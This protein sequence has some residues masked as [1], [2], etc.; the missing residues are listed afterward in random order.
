MPT[1]TSQ[2]A[3]ALADLFA[4][5]TT[6]FAEPAYL[7]GLLAELGYQVPDLTGQLPLFTEVMAIAEPLAELSSSAAQLEDDPDLG[8]VATTMV[9]TA[10]ALFDAIHALRELR[11][12]DLNGLVAPFD[13]PATWVELAG[14]LPSY[15]V[16]AWLEGAHPMVAGALRL[17]GVLG[18]KPAPGA[19]PATIDW[20][21]LGALVS[22]PVARI[23]STSG[24]GGAFDHAAL[25]E[26]VAEVARGAGYTP[27]LSPLR[28]DLI[29]QFWNGY[30]GWDP[31][32]LGVRLWSGFSLGGSTYTRLGLVLAAVPSTPT[33]TTPDALLLTAAAD[34]DLA[35]SIAV[36]ATWTA[37]LAGTVAA[38]GSLGAMLTP[39]GLLAVTDEATLD[40]GLELEAAPA[41]PWIV[42]GGAGTTRFEVRG[43]LLGLSL[44]GTTA[45]PELIGEVRPSAGTQLVLALGD[46]DG[47]LGSLLGT[48]EIAIA[49]AP[50]LRW[51]SRDGFSFGGT[52]GFEL[53]VPIGLAL[54]PLFIDR[55]H[56]ALT[57]GDAGLEL[58]ATT[59]LGAAL[60]PFA[61][62]VEDIGLRFGV[63]SRAADDARG[64]FGAVGVA[65]GFLPP[66]GLGLAV[67]LGALG[68]GG[69]YLEC[70]PDEGKYDGV[71]DLDLLG[72]GVTAIG[73][74]T[75][76]AA[77]GWSLFLS[78]SATFTGVQL[79]FGFTLNG[80]GGL[81]GVN[82]A[83]DL[84]AL[85]D[86]VRSGALE[87]LLFPDDPVADAPRILADLDAI[88]PPA[89]GQYVFGPMAKIGWGTP[90]LATVDLG[91]VMQLPDPIT[92]SLLGSFEA[93]LPAPEA[94]ILELRVDVAGT[95]DVTNGTL[96]VDASLRDSRVAGLALSGDMSMRAVFV[97]Q[98]SFLMSF[99]GFNPRFVPPAGF[100]QLKRLSVALDGGDALRLE[101]AGYFA[102]TSNTVQFGSSCEV[103][104]HAVGLTVEGDFHFDALL[105]FDPFWFVIDLGFGV[106]VRAGSFELFAVHLDFMLEG[107]KP[108]HALGTATVKILGV[109]KDF[110][111]EVTLGGGPTTV[112]RD[113]IDVRALVVD[114]L[115]A[116]DAWREL[117]PAADGQA[118]TLGDVPAGAE[119]RVHPASVLEVRQRVAPLDVTLEQY[120]NATV[121]G[122]DR[123]ELS[124]P[125]LGGIAAAG[126]PLTDWFA[127]AQYFV[128]GDAEKLSSPSFELMTCGMQLGEVGAA[129]GPASDLELGYEQVVRDPDVTEQ[130]V[131]LAA[132]HA[133]TSAALAAAVTRSAVATLRRSKGLP[134]AASAATPA[135][136]ALGEVRYV[137][138]DADTG[139]VDGTVTPATGVSWSQARAARATRASVQLVPS[140]EVEAA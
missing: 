56:V 136:F 47:F 132:V 82:R 99:G 23:R 87:G 128:L 60:G 2:L 57:G 115:S 92:V 18:R 90:T 29:D 27:A 116:A 83:V 71:A 94:P 51:S 30:A 105:Q 117:A 104:A 45:A 97:G 135:A 91:I 75:T 107:P 48:G 110:H 76:E 28:R 8:A 4:P 81:V 39:S 77:G 108:W 122:L 139:A 22:D 109:K 55:V 68:G 53:D 93:I 13:E 1:F 59:S 103:Y 24:F 85:S 119:L 106:T 133:P 16:V 65:L 32:E 72:I 80:V 46:A 74:L 114:A 69:G 21:G 15:L 120:G 9:E 111:V 123:F 64:N 124:A 37:R 95:L 38:T 35:A 63:E 31:R 79:G 131:P 138:T 12:N 50:A 98:P 112:T 33:S 127:P 11:A 102:I 140:Y 84:D 44:Q 70:R 34:G 88:F 118:V 26:A 54:G 61:F 100:P 25:L 89:E 130:D 42:L 113:A 19:P 10:T 58:R 129:A 41:A 5:L 134:T 43:V 73:V 125:T 66:A 126:T 62:V 67:D 40:A 121:T 20:A 3:G 49:L 52:A 14:R 6:A 137:A 96:A 17:T 101:L 7:G 36:D 86:G 78:L